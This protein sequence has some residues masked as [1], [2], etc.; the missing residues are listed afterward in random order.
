MPYP[1]V[2][3]LSRVILAEP[4]GRYKMLRPGVD[5][6]VLAGA[7]EHGCAGY[8][9]IVHI[10]RLDLV[11][12]T[13]GKTKQLFGKIRGANHVIFNSLDML[14]LGMRGA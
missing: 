14:P 6:K 4:A 10:N 5:S 13:A 1:A 3:A 11:L 2:A 12:A 8:N 7:A 9:Q